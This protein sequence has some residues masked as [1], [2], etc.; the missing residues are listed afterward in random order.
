MELLPEEAKT[1]S[2]ILKELKKH[3]D[4]G[5]I[6]ISNPNIANNIETEILPAFPLRPKEGEPNNVNY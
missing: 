2:Q 6:D 1:S 5:T 3:V 4:F